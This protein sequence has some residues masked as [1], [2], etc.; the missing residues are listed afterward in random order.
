MRGTMFSLQ[1]CV[2]NWCSFC[3]NSKAIEIEWV[4]DSKG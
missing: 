1:F 4:A 3:V 2:Y